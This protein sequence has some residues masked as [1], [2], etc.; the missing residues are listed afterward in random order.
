[1]LTCL[2]KRPHN[3]VLMLMQTLQYTLAKPL[4]V[5][6][7]PFPFSVAHCW[8]GMCWY[9]QQGNGNNLARVDLAAG[10]TGTTGFNPVIVAILLLCNTYSGPVSALLFALHSTH[11]RARVLSA[12][13]W[14]RI[15]VMV[16]VLTAVICFREHL[17]I[18]TV[19][20]PKLLYEVACSVFLS[21]CFIGLS[22][23]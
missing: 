8:I 12:Y 18:W 4:L 5:R 10:Y 22:L 15:V 23:F 14:C 19:F 17:F 21:L 16:V 13:L 1:M 11:N 9:F 3:V 7:D 6:M 20:S 2:L